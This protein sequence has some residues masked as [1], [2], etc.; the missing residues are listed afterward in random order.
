MS[1]PETY[2]AII[3]NE[4]GEISVKGF[5]LPQ[6]SKNQVLV[7]VEFAPLNPTDFMKINGFYGKPA[8]YG[9][10]LHGSEGS[11]VVVAVGNSLKYPFQVGDRVHIWA[12]SWGQYVLTESDNL[13]HILQRDLSFEDAASHWIN[14]ATVYYM[15]V[16]ADR[17]GHKAAIHTAGSSALGR[18][19]I[20]YFKSKDIKLINIVRKEEFVEELEREG[21]DY[22]LNSQAP[23][24]E[25]R[26]KEIVEKENATLAFDAIGGDFTNKILKAQPAESE[27]LVYGTLAGFQVKN[28]DIQELFKGKRVGSLF[29]P[30]YAEQLKKKGEFEK[31][32]D[33]VHNLLPTL[34][35]SSVQKVFKI[36]DIKEAAAY[37][38][39]NSSKGKILIK[40]N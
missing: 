31:F 27:A 13:S 1:L 29:M 35:G 2:K 38:K 40:P 33:D 36:D 17:G 6:P 26:L 3:G 24:F 19:L 16:L 32:R 15:G 12:E 39:E 25:E 4:K 20:K 22:V 30:T 18:M 8:D 5:P 23:D 21:A 9:T 34:L 10:A 7:K 28:V 37:W 11:G 14:P